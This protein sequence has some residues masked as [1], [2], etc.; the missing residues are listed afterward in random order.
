MS[1]RL[2]S[3]DRGGASWPLVELTLARLRELSREPEAIFWLFFFPIMMTIAMAIAF[4]SSAGR[5]V[6]VGVAAGEGAA[7]MR[8]ALEEAPGVSVRLVNPDEEQRLLREGA[9]HVV[10]VPAAPPIYR[11][12]PSMRRY[13]WQNGNSYYQ[14]Q[15]ALRYR[16]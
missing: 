13:N 12:D 3:K 6:V 5:D 14:I 16:F 8:A 11:F 1:D 4:P 2:S 9:V 15:L 10:V 7:R